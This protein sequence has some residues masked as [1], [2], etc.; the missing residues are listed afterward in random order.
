MKRDTKSKLALLILVVTAGTIWVWRMGYL[1]SPVHRSRIAYPASFQ[2]DGKGRP[3]ITS[4]VPEPPLQPEA[5]QK[6]NVCNE[7]LE[8]DSDDIEALLDAF[9]I[10]CEANLNA[11]AVPYGERYRYLRLKKKRRRFC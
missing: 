6:L 9:W 5:R 10:L 7:V 3:D 11:S 2:T 4:L 1:S 8:Q